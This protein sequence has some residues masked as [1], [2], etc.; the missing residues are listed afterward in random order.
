MTC[1]RILLAALSIA[2][3]S[4]AIAHGGRPDIVV[5]RKCAYDERRPQYSQ[6]I[7]FIFQLCSFFLSLFISFISLLLPSLLLGEAS[8][9]PVE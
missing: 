3:C 7:F 8:T 2:A 4:D 6:I 1:A 9:M 5:E